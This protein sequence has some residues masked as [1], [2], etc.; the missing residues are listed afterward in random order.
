MFPPMGNGIKSCNLSKKS[1]LFKANSKI[2]DF[3]REAG[4]KN[5]L[6]Y[7][8]LYLKAFVSF[9]LNAQALLCKQGSVFRALTPG[10]FPLFGSFARAHPSTI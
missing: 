6:K 5:Q 9:L 4:A 10:L 2:P 1:I 8:D 3:E 7:L